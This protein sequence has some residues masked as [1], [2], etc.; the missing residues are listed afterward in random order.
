[1]NCPLTWPLFKSNFFPGLLLHSNSEKDAQL[2]QLTPGHF[3]RVRHLVSFWSNSGILQKVFHPGN[4]SNH[5]WPYKC[6][7]SSML[8]IKGVRYYRWLHVYF[9]SVDF[10]T[11]TMP[12]TSI[13]QASISPTFCDPHFPTP[14]GC[15]PESPPEGTW[16]HP[17][18]TLTL[19]VSMIQEINGSGLVFLGKKTVDC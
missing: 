4:Y 14:K 17:F 13:P 16:Y 1:M 6:T 15:I 5:A 8:S 2:F 7:P 18:G 9:P 11:V 12:T 3:G 10:L 19:G